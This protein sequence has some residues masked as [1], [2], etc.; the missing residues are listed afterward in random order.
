[1][2]MTDRMLSRRQ[3]L[4]RTGQ[5]GLAAALAPAALARAAQPDDKPRGKA[6]ACIFLWLGG[7][8]A[9][10][11]T[12][13]PKRLG[14]PKAKRAGSAYPAIPTTA[15]GVQVCEHLRQTALVLDRAVPVRTLHHNVIDEHAAT[16]RPV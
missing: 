15:P 5:A 3:F 13:D 14:D 10:V 7:G 2:P 1:M 6:D 9:H 16:G 12:F 11:D 8:A 4:A